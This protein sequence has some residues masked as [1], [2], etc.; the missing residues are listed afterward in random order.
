MENATDS[1]SIFSS[2]SESATKENANI[3]M[4]VLLI[5]IQL[6]KL[7]HRGALRSSC[8]G[9][10]VLGISISESGIK[11]RG[12]AAITPRATEL[13]GQLEKALKGEVVEA[14]SL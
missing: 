6:G 9:K 3:G 1:S 5:V 10:E 12:K 8:F 4:L 2:L 7:L 11:T 13:I 14:T